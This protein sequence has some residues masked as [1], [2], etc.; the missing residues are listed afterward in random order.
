MLIEITITALVCILIAAQ[1]MLAAKQIKKG[2]PDGR[3]LLKINIIFAVIWIPV[4][5]TKFIFNNWPT[6]IIWVALATIYFI[7]VTWYNNELKK[8]F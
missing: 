8:T 7:F 1:L 4:C 6:A 2:A 5:I 3:I